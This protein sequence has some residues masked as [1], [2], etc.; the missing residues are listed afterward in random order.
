MRKMIIIRFCPILRLFL[1]TLEPTEKYKSI[2]VSKIDETFILE[3][4]YRN[5][6][7]L[8]SPKKFS[9]IYDKRIQNEWIY[10]EFCYGKIDEVFE[11]LELGWGG[12]QNILKPI[13]I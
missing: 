12:G 6:N 2:L 9:T 8:N 1:L 13:A 5:I 10:S 7:V 4:V 11:V 3:V